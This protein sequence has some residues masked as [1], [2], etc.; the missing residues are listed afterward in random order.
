MLGFAGKSGLA[1]L[2]YYN[3]AQ[4]TSFLRNRTGLHTRPDV[5]QKYGMC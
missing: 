5:D 3:Y 4:S 2:V 1:S